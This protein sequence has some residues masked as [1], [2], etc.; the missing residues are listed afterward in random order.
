MS[1]HIFWTETTVI[2]T[3]DENSSFDLAKRDDRLLK[4]LNVY[5]FLA[6]GPNERQKNTFQIELKIKNRRDFGHK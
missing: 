6:K 3:L 4:F 1:S 2:T 5:Q